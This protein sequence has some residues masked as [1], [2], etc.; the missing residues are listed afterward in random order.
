MSTIDIL[1]SVNDYDK[2]GDVADQGVFLHFRDARVKVARDMEEFRALPA[3][4]QSMVDEIAQNYPEF[5]E[6]E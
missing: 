2:D 6:G 1:F 3:R 4:I 5:A